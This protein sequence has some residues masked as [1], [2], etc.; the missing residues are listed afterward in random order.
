MCRIR[1]CGQLD[2]ISRKKK[3]MRISVQSVMQPSVPATLP[4][5]TFNQ[6]WQ[7]EGDG[8]VL[9]PTTIIL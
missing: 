2:E 9:P 5:K 3:D 4:P 7:R 1:S 6:K 8:D